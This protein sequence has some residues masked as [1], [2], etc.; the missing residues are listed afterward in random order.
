MAAAIRSSPLNIVTISISYK[1]RWNHH[2][3]MPRQTRREPTARGQAVRILRIRERKKENKEYKTTRLAKRNNKT[4]EMERHW[5]YRYVYTTRRAPMKWGRENARGYSMWW[6][7]GGWGVKHF[8]NILPPLRLF[9][10]THFET[11]KMNFFSLL[12]Y[13]GDV[14]SLAEGRLQKTLLR[15]ASRSSS[16]LAGLPFH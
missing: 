3:L 8:I 6:Y 11:I 15:V 12:S 4:A 16:F 9:Y 14:V 13:F 1:E 2:H 10:I 7:H 5:D